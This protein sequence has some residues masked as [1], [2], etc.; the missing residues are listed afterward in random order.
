MEKPTQR[1]CK[2]RGHYPTLRSSPRN[3]GRVLNAGG[4]AGPFLRLSTKKYKTKYTQ[5]SPLLK[6]EES[7][8]LNFSLPKRMFLGGKQSLTNVIFHIKIEAQNYARVQHS[9]FIK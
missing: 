3:E 7:K 5:K 8:P 4:D 1:V 9:E 2:S 6:F